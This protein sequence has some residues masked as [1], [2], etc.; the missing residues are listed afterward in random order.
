MLRSWVEWRVDR[1]VDPPVPDTSD[2]AADVVTGAVLSEPGA[3]AENPD[4]GGPLCGPLGGPGSVSTLRY[5]VEVES[6]T[7]VTLLR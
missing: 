1:P 5:L 4:P 6:P 2:A 3:L 7:K